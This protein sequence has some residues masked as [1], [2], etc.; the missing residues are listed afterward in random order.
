[1][2]PLLYA[3]DR[4]GDPS[5]QDFQL[6]GACRPICSRREQWV[7]EADPIPVELEHPCR[8]QHSYGRL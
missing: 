6:A 4:L 2:S 1:M 7:S 3:V 8:S 5:V